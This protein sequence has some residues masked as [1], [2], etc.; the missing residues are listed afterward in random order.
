MSSVWCYRWEGQRYTFSASMQ[1]KR[2]QETAN[3]FPQRL[4]SAK[5]KL[6][7]IPAQNKN[8]NNCNSQ[9][10][11]QLSTVSQIHPGE[12]IM[13]FW[14]RNVILGHSLQ[15]SVRRCSYLLSLMQ[16]EPLQLGCTPSLVRG[17]PLNACHLPSPVQSSEE[18]YSCQCQWNKGDP[19]FSVKTFASQ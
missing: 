10:L 8:N 7:H 14:G 6:H 13:I 1:K 11:I 17:D 4:D 18:E 9:T 5:E 3:F 2:G 19:S 15:F 16:A 12:E